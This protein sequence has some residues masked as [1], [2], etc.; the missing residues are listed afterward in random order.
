MKHI[1]QAD[2]YDA[3][4]HEMAGSITAEKAE[5]EDLSP[6]RYHFYCSDCLKGHDHFTRLKRVKGHEACDVG[7]KIT[8]PPRF[9][10][11]RKDHSTH[12]CDHRLRF[13]EMDDLAARYEAKS[14]GDH[15]YSFLMNMGNCVDPMVM[16]GV[17]ESVHSAER[18]RKILY[19][20]MYDPDL[21]AQQTLYLGNQHQPLREVVYDQTQREELVRQS[22]IKSWT[23]KEFYAAVIFK[24]MARRDYWHTLTDEFGIPAQPAGQIDVRG[25]VMTPNIVLRF[26]SEFVRTAVKDMV[27]RESGNSSAAVLAFGRVVTARPYVDRKIKEAKRVGKAERVP[28]LQTALWINAASDV[29]EWNYP[30][31]FESMIEQQEGAPP[32][33]GQRVLA[34]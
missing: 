18:L 24:P 34:L 5:P 19:A 1:V 17:G 11:Y 33:S 7:V 12:K 2:V 15:S 3:I 21:F 10:L 29:T 30:P 13:Q 27:S 22:I 4:R 8:L 26:K 25:A 6:D 16:D 9:V 28:I 31:S 32:I 23:Q 20:G 14:Q